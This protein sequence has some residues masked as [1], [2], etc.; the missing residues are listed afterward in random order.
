VKSGRR[1]K[2]RE[3]DRERD[4]NREKTVLNEMDY[5]ID[6]D[7]G[8]RAA[9]YKVVRFVVSRDSGTRWW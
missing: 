1:E 8:K 4:G 6:R 5:I 3:R 9:D 2:E 7:T